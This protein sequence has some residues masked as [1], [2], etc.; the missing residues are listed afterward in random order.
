ME[1][2]GVLQAAQQLK[3]LQQK[4]TRWRP[5]SHKAKAEPIDLVAT[6]V[7]KRIRGQ[8][9]EAAVQVG[10]KANQPLYL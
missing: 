7:S 9:I 3:T 10:T 1:E 8:P 2:M 6:R 4:P 5:P